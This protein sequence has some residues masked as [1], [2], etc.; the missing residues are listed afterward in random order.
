M[1][2]EEN[3]PISPRVDIAAYREAVRKHNNKIR[4]EEVL[5]AIPKILG[6][7]S[8]FAAAIV[9]TYF[10]TQWLLASRRIESHMPPEL[11]IAMAVIGAILIVAGVAAIVKLIV[12]TILSLNESVG[13]HLHFVSIG[14]LVVGAAVIGIAIIVT[15]YLAVFYNV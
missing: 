15:L 14:G 13:F 4:R 6:I 3:V 10:V 11:L 5:R 2:T 12:N 1:S 9:A 8:L 7:V